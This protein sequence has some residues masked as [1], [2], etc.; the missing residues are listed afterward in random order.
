M[1]S[2]NHCICMPQNF[3]QKV[4]AKCPKY[5]NINTYCATRRLTYAGK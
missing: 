5:V 4:V 1:L 3:R 2:I